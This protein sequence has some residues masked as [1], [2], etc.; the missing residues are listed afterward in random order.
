MVLGK[1][2][3]TTSGS[4]PEIEHLTETSTNLFFEHSNPKILRID[5]DPGYKC[6]AISMFIMF[7]DQT[8]GKGFPKSGADRS[9]GGGYNAYQKSQVESIIL[10]HVFS[11]ILTNMQCEISIPRSCQIS[12]NNSDP[13]ENMDEIF[14]ANIYIYIWGCWPKNL[15]VTIS[16]ASIEQRSKPNVLIGFLIL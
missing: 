1:D 3:R 14:W 15:Y 11:E 4:L 10:H 5:T 8:F 6:A 13:W 2:P 16:P 12:R 9:T 7:H